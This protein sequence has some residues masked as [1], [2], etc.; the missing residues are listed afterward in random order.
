MPRRVPRPIPKALLAAACCAIFLPDAAAMAQ[1]A[2]LPAQQVARLDAATAALDRPNAPGCAAG[3]MR[4]GSLVYE[5]YAGSADLDHGVRIGPRTKFFIES[6]SK[7]FTAMAIILLALDHRLSLDDDVRRYVPELPNYGE[8]ITLR[9]L[10]THTSG[11]RDD[12]NLLLMAGWR[13]SDVQTQDDVLDFVRGQQH[14]NFRPGDEYMY[15]N[16]GYTL[17]AL[18]V[19]RVSGKAF[20][21]F[22]AERIFAPLGMTDSEF[23]EDAGRVIADRAIGYWPPEEGRY[24]I[25]RP[26]FAYAGPTGL[27]T[28]LRD[29]ARWDGNYEAMTVG[30]RAARDL[31]Y[32]RGRLNDGT[33]TGYGLGIY[34]GEYRGQPIQS[35]A[36]SGPGY[37]AEFI[38]FPGQRLGIAVICNTFDII[39]TPI[40]HAMADVLIPAPAAAAGSAAGVQALPPP[41]DIAALAG[42]YWNADVAQ[43]ARFL[44]E[45]GKLLIDAGDEGRFELRP[46]GGH[47]F[48]LPAA[49]RRYVLAFSDGADGRRRV[50]IE[51]AGERSREF[52]AVAAA[53]IV[54]LPSSYAGLYYSRELDTYWTVVRR[55]DGLAVVRARYGETPLTALLP[56]IFQMNGGFFTL[57]FAPPVDGAAPAF[58]VTTERVRRLRFVRVDP[59]RD[60]P[61]VAASDS[62]AR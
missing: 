35:H 25:A 50:R 52:V 46:I 7:Q 53:G 32:A 31:M 1:P 20:P 49:P 23:V 27:V 59:P 54:P 62:A 48:L 10:L 47:T 45:D 28:T 56:D 3:V 14:L 40:A 57:V 29:L 4:A 30:G 2:P 34:L 13:I 16:T 22:V 15:S 21:Q 6:S 8:A 11:L 55:G 61:A 39:P 33:P 58:E 43:A 19:S 9:H 5:R 18:V 24:R 51:I 12:T 44:F 36:G 26:P 60:E 37:K 17:L 38:R 41:P 42:T